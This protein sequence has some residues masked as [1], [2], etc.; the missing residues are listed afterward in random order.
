MILY[1]LPPAVRAF[2]DFLADE[3]PET[4]ALDPPTR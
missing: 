3:L 4:V 1:S 2:V